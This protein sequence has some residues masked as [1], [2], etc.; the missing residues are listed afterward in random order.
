MDGST[1]KEGESMNRR[2]HRVLDEIRRTEQKIAEWLEHLKE[3]KLLAEQ[4]E[5]QEIVKSIRS[6]KLDSR[7]MLALLEGIQDGTVSIQYER[8]PDTASEME[9]SETIKTEQGAQDALESEGK[10]N[11]E[12]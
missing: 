7:R 6:M 12:L 10:K 11:E 5:N 2:L 9:P 8:E 1:K 3:L 4:L